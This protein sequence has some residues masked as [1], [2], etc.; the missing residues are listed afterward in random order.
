LSS[1]WQ[2]P[3]QSCVLCRLLHRGL[4]P[5]SLFLQHLLQLGLQAGDC[6][7]H[8]HVPYVVQV[9]HASQGMVLAL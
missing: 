8:Q 2:L 5:T 6:H 1:S 4:H 3:K 7:W 9:S